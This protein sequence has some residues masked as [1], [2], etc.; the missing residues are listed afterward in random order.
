M[1]LGSMYKPS[2]LKCG[3]TIHELRY[4]VSQVYYQSPTSTFED[5]K[6]WADY[7]SICLLH[8]V[9]CPLLWPP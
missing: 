8:W 6:H 9:D 4:S 7:V 1:T 2:I 3:G 5:N